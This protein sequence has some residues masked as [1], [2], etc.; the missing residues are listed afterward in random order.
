MVNENIKKRIKQNVIFLYP[1]PGTPSCRLVL[2]R[3][4]KGNNKQ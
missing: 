1:M 2:A 3:A 4:C